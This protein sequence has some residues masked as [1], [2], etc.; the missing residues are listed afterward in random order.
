LKYF[1]HLYYIAR[2]LILRGPLTSLSL[3]NAERRHE[4]QFNI[5]T[6]EF[7][8]SSSSQYFHYQ[9]ASYH[10]LF[11]LFESLDPLT[12]EFHFIDIGS[13]KGRTVFVAEYCGFTI[14]TGIELNKNLVKDAKQNL[15]T[16][17]LK[18]KDSK[19]NFIEINALDFDYKNEP[20]VYFLFNPFNARV[21]KKVLERIRAATISETWFV[22]M[23]PLYASVFKDAGIKQ[24]KVIKSGFYT[25]AIIYKIKPAP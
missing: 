12:K 2:S 23:N 25:E 21:L 14:L 18:K 20:A 9:G 17:S 6:A 16:F 1:I 13:G 7:I 22:Y 11:R 3:F 24:E 4:K 15:T 19:I 5:Q 8:K 10:V